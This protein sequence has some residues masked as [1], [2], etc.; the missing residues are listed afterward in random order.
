MSRLSRQVRRRHPTW[1]ALVRAQAKVAIGLAAAYDGPVFGRLARVLGG[2]VREDDAS[3]AG[4]PAFVYRPG[5][6]AGPWP[7]T[8]LFPGVTRRGRTHPALRAIGRGLAGAGR[9]AILVE[10]EGLPFGELTPTAGQQARAAIETV[11]SRRDVADGSTA[12]VGVSGGATL[13][14]LAAS[15][16]SLRDRVSLVLVVAPLNDVSE[17]IRYITT[18]VRR[19]GDAL[20][21]FVSG[22]FFKLVIARSVI[23]CLQ[24]GSDRTALRSH[25]LALDDYGLEP[26]S[27]L[28][29]WPRGRLDE[30]ARAAVALLSNAAPDRFDEL[31]AA[32]PESLRA[33]VNA[34]SPITV[35][36][37]IT[38][39]VELVVAGA[40]KYIPLADAISFAKAC[41]TA[42]L[43]V[44]ESL[45]H[46][47]PTVSP[48]GARDLARLDGVLVRLL[49]T[50]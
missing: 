36:S 44:L 16:R 12:L 23:A 26:L 2:S 10:P 20:T 47:V 15:D 4:L 9:L 32:L 21:P 5:R 19:D 43:T 50:S 31:F 35:A 7:A 14:L 18:D 33:A 45:T 49:A 1:P 37:E 11:A 29:A 46:V 8:V 22:D 17:A 38:A 39:P 24:P 3:V 13:A 34:L 27:G 40:D 41:P 48:T 30:P 25:L 6:G 42:R 28:R